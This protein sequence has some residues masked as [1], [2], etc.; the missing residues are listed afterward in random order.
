MP[1]KPL[2]RRLL[3]KPE[4]IAQTSA[5]GIHLPEYSLEKPATGIV[6]AQGTFKP[7][8]VLP[9]EGDRVYFRPGYGKDVEIN[10]EQHILIDIDDV[11][12]VLT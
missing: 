10:G 3:I 5:G 6:I 4:E 9:N 11:L 12:G 8:D 1:L 7:E 2:G